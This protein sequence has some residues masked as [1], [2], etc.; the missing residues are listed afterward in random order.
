MH[1]RNSLQRMLGVV[2]VI[3]LLVGCAAP[4]A[5]PTP[6]QLTPAATPVPPTPTPVPSTPTPV[7]P[8]ATPT[9]A[10]LGIGDTASLDV[11]KFKVTGWKHQDSISTA[12]YRWSVEEG[13]TFLTV[14][15]RLKNSSEISST[16][17]IELN[18]VAVRDAKGQVYPSGGMGP[19]GG[20]IVYGPLLEGSIQTK[21]S[22]SNGQTVIFE[23][24][25]V[26]KTDKSATLTASGNSEFDCYIA[27]L[28]PSDAE[29]FNLEWP[30]LPSFKLE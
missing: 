2:L 25:A 24:T 9:P 16:L 12:I 6:M 29:G 15:F 8:T 13:S 14:D 27:F 3:L 23:V 20:F 30:G 21:T 22:P 7:S 18:K 10:V 19:V 28:V 17:Q 26:T 11:W 1:H 5:T 4:T